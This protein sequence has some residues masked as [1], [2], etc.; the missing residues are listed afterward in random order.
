MLK[1]SI[2]LICLEC[3]K[4]PLISYKNDSELLIKCLCGNTKVVFIK[5]YLE[6]IKNIKKIIKIRNYCLFHENQE[7]EFYCH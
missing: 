5:D 7:L 3:K 2:P 4:F 1:H 6:E